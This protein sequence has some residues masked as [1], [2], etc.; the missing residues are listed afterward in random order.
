MWKRCNWFCQLDVLIANSVFVLP[1]SLQ[2]ARALTH[3]TARKTPQ[4]PLRAADVRKI[5][6]IDIS[7]VQEMG[8]S[9]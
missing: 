5:S 2:M 3:K 9:G 4:T 7:K 8:C 1:I 6:A